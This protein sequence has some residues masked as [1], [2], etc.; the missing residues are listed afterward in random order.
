[1]KNDAHIQLRELE[2]SL[3]R[4]QRD[5]LDYYMLNYD[6]DDNTVFELLLILRYIIK[7]YD[8]QTR[9]SDEEIE[10]FWLKISVR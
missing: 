4:N 7:F 1:M 2:E 5:V 6:N 10:Q 3:N 9:M 8:G